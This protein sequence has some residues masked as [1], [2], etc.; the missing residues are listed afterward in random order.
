MRH[1]FDAFDSIPCDVLCG[2]CA[3]VLVAFAIGAHL[4]QWRSE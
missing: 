1:F 3:V 4:A 2:W